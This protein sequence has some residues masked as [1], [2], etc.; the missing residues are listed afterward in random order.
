MARDGPEEVGAVEGEQARGSQG[1]D[2]RGP[3]DPVEQRDLTEAVTGGE[4]VRAGH[5]V[6]GDPEPP[7]GHDVEA[8]ADVALDDH[9][10]AVLGG[11]P[12][13]RAG[14]LLELVGAQDLEERDLPQQLDLRRAG[15]RPGVEP[16]QRDDGGQGEEGRTGPEGQE[17]RSGAERLDEERR[18]AGPEGEGNQRRPLLDAE[19]PGEHAVVGRALQ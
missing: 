4:H 9:V 18:D 8:V 3:G 14:E 1:R 19:D 2:G 11:E 7:V 16:Q 12:P 15:L 10:G 17:R 6:D 5:V 13:R